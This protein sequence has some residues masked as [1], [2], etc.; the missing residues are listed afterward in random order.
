[1]N[2]QLL[3]EETPCGNFLFQRKNFDIKY[4]RLKTFNVDSNGRRFNCTRRH[5]TKRRHANVASHNDVTLT[6]Q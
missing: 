6:T 1:M 5:Q 2:D 3:S 4:Y